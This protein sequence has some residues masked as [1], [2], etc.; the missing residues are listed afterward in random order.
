MQPFSHHSIMSWLYAALQYRS[1]KSLNFLVFHTS[2]HIS[3]RPATFLFLIFFRTTSN[4]SWVKDYHD[5]IYIYIY[6]HEGLLINKMKMPLGLAKGSTFYSC[7]FFKEINSDASFYVL[8]NSL[9]DFFRLFKM[10]AY[11]SASGLTRGLSSIFAPGFF[12]TR[13][14]VCFHSFDLF[15]RLKFIMGSP[16]SALL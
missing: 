9:H 1:G 16:S 3:S 14:S 13:E 5:F 7:T 10:A 12:F 6:I 15:S 11:Q 4:F 8:E 2:G